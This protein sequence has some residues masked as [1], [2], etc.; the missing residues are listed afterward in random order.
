M[1]FVSLCN[2]HLA[3][4]YIAWFL[5]LMLTDELLSESEISTEQGG[6]NF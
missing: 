3:H 6:K 5:D 1:L 2:M 4:N